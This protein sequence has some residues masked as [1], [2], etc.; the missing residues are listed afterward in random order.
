[1]RRMSYCQALIEA[2]KEE[3]LRDSNVVIM[4][5]PGDVTPNRKNLP[6]DIHVWWDDENTDNSE[7][8][9]VLAY[10]LQRNKDWKNKRICLKAIV[11]NE[12]IRQNKLK[13]FQ[14]LSIKVR[15]PLDIEVLVSSEPETNYFDF[16]RQFSKHA[17]FIFL[18]LVPP[19][20]DGEP[21]DEYIDYL[22]RMSVTPKDFPE[23]ALVL[24]SEHTPL[25]TILS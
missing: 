22:H 4:N 21:V 7:F 15:L 12:F 14:E 23:I 2:Q 9:L 13:E 5:E 18:S 16:V 8:M 1:M 19:P 25:E 24:S 17:E 11:K 20:Q 3:M 6:G 10:M